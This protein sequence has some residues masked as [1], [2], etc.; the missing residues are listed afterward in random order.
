MANKKLYNRKYLRK[1]FATGI[2]V[3]D[4]GE[5]AEKD[6][7]AKT[8]VYQ[9]FRDECGRAYIYDSYLKRRLYLDSLTLT[10]FRCL[11]PQDGKT[12]FPYHKDGNMKNAHISNLEWR[13]ETADTIAAYEK[14]EKESWYKNR[15]ISVT[16]KGI[17]RQG[18][19]DLSLDYSR[20]DSDVD[21]TYHYPR[22]WINY[23]EKNRWGETVRCEI[24][25][26][27]IFEDLGLVKGDK[28]K[29]S[30]PVI[31]HLNNDFLDYSPDNL[32]WC[33]RYDPQFMEF[34]KIRHDE[35]M[36]RDHD[37]NYR[38]T[39]SEWD[40]IY[41]GREPYQEWNDLPEKILRRFI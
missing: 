11:P 35:V 15:R 23:E 12:Y 36:Q 4:D 2:Y 3:S 13:E 41:H 38:L 1:H 14:L 16:N 7:Y 5:Y 20:Y 37:C 8:I 10:C 40:V 21:W 34:E 32:E 17:I 39:E 24:Y 27:K 22:P 31:I 33:D 25:A 19:H 29:F 18:T 26:D 9:I 30:N 28:S 6:I